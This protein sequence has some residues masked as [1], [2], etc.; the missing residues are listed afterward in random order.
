MWKQQH[1][2]CDNIHAKS[3]YK[4]LM[5]M[6]VFVKLIF[7]GKTEYVALVNKKMQKP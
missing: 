3:T 7:R 1:L 4:N 2:L 5:Y 6:H